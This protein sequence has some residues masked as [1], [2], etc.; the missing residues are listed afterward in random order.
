MALYNPLLNTRKYFSLIESPNHYADTI[1]FRYKIFFIGGGGNSEIN[2]VLQ[3]NVKSMK[4]TT[5]NPMLICK[6]EVALCIASEDIYSLG[7]YRQGFLSDCQKYSIKF[8][9]WERLSNL[10]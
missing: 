3:L 8:D 2:L 1:A 4:F 10:N 5:K 7:G 6:F 9:K